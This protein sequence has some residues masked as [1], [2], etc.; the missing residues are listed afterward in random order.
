MLDIQLQSADMLC[1]TQG[2][3]RTVMAFVKNADIHVAI[4]TVVSNA[5]YTAMTNGENCRLN[6]IRRAT[7]HTIN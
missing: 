4:G 6:I 3:R 2:M 1:N 5:S 7:A